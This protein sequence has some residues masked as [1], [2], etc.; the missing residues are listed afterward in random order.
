[1]MLVDECLHR[2]EFDRRHAERL[3]VGDD[4]TVRQPA[5]RAAF[6]LVQRWMPHREAADVEFVEDRLGPANRRTGAHRRHGVRDHGLRDEPGAV[7]VACLVR[8]VAQVVEYRIVPAELAVEQ[9][10]VGVDQQLRGIAA[11]AMGRIPQAMDAIA[12]ALP[13]L[14][15]GDEAVPDVARALRQVDLDAERAAQTRRELEAVTRRCAQ[16]GGTSGVH[17]LPLSSSSSSRQM[18]SL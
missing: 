2:H 7:E 6:A 16:R 13:G 3:E 17:Q 10:R 9:A 5:E 4:F 12:I 14:E 8:P 11:Q 1:M 18:P 15:A